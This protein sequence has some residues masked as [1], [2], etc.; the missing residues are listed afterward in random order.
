[1]ASETSPRRAESDGK[2]AGNACSICYLTY[3]PDMLPETRNKH[4]I[5]HLNQEPSF[6]KK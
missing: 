6:N 5:E 4:M 3:P 2:S 1:M